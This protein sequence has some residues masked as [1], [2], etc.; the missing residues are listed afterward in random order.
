MFHI[1]AHLPEIFSDAKGA[2]QNAATVL[3]AGLTAAKDKS[4]ANLGSN[5]FANDP[6]RDDSMPVGA[7]PMM[8]FSD[9]QA[10]P[11][12][13]DDVLAPVDDVEDMPEISQDELN[14]LVDDFFSKL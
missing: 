9:L 4:L 12:E 2:V 3:V 14:K 7:E 13:K 1:A 11:E 8:D 10:A 5:P 6:M